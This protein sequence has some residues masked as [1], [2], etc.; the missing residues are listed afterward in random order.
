MLIRMVSVFRYALTRT[1]RSL[2]ASAAEAVSPVTFIESRGIST[3]ST[4]IDPEPFLTYSENWI[5][6]TPDS[7]SKLG[8]PSAIVG[9]SVSPITRIDTPD[10]AGSAF[11]ARSKNVDDRSA[12]LQSPLPQS[13]ALSR[14]E[15]FWSGASFI[16]TL[17]E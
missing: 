17:R 14:S 1:M 4:L 6:R 10:A 7:R 13:G 2:S 11:P 12:A 3:P 5:S 9:L 8:D 15:V 16:V